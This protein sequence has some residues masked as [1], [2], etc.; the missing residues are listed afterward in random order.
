MTQP[1]DD[2][3][4]DLLRRLSGL[5]SKDVGRAAEM[6]SPNFSE[7]DDANDKRWWKAQH[8]RTINKIKRIF[9]WFLLLATCGFITLSAAGYLYLVS[10]WLGTVLYG[11]KVHDPVALKSFI[12]GVLWSLLIVF[13]TLF[14]EGTFKDK[15]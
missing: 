5:S 6:K 8:R 7:D 3:D 4:A 1:S 15:D 2:G 14:F 9:F 10:L 12:D 11:T 13:A